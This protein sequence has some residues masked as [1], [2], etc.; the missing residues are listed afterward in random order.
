M[1]GFSARRWLSIATSSL[2]TLTHCS[3]ADTN[4]FDQHRDQMVQRQIRARGVRDPRVLEALRL[5]PRHEFVPTHL[6][7]R[8]Y[9][10]TALPLEQRQTISQPYVVAA[11]TEAAELEASDRVLEIGT[12]SGYQAAVLAELTE[13]VYSIEIVPELA[14][15]AEKRL[16]ALGYR[17]WPEAAPFDAILVTAAPTQV[18]APLLDQLAAGGRL[19]IPVGAAEQMLRVFTRTEQSIVRTDLF[20]VRFVPMTGKSEREGR[21]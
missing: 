5:V 6:R 9:D 2:T 18:P 19:V 7:D 21:D 8:A 15:S 20:G 14:A 12:E 3:A 11:M 4:S 16:A 10:D 13:T 17:G 1:K